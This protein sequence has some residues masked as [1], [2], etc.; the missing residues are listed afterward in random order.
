MFSVFFFLI[1]RLITANEIVK[2]LP[3][4]CMI[5]YDKGTYYKDRIWIAIANI[6]DP[7][8]TL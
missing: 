7:F 2:N 8:C 6:R 5:L 3:K 1:C 4:E